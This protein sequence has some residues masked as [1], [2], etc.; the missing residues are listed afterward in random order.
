[1]ELIQDIKALYQLDAASEFGNGMRMLFADAFD[2]QGV[3]FFKA[4]MDSAYPGALDAALAGDSY[5]LD[6]DT[7][8]PIKVFN[9]MPQTGYMGDLVQ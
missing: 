7:T 2:I 6:T 1:V 5:Q 9:T 8:T 4:T 3:N